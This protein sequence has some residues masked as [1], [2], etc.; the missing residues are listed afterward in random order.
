MIKEILRKIAELQCRYPFIIL[1]FILIITIIIGIGAANLEIQSDFSKQQPRQLPAYVLTDRISDEFGGENAV[2]LIFEVD[3]ND[4]NELI[5]LRDPAFVNFLIDFE[6]TLKEDSRVISTSSIGTIMQ[7]NPPE[8]RE[9]IINFIKAVPQLNSLFSEDYRMT[10]LTITTNIGGAY[11]DV[12]PFEEMLTN[13]MK[14]VDYPGGVKYTMTG[15]PAFGKTI[16]EVVFSD[17]L[18]T[19]VFAAIGIFLLLLITE[20]SLIKSIIVFTPLIF[21]IIWTGGIIGH[22]G[23]K[24]SI[25]SVALTSIILGLGVEYGVFMLSRYHEERFTNKAKQIDANQNAVSNIGLALLSSGTTT[26]AGFIALT[27]SFTP[28]MQNLGLSLAIGILTS[29]VAAIVVTPLM[30]IIAENYEINWLEKNAG[31]NTKK[32]DFYKNN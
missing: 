20:K 27:F 12:V 4:E 30:I 21:A 23:M 28:M 26:F 17:S 24:L 18:K 29:I 19:F 6:E 14:S 5:D 31:K 10:I 25:A 2:V 1:G 32:R 16:R 8:Q 11:E 7:S 22:I 3:E 15:G 13:K 9:D